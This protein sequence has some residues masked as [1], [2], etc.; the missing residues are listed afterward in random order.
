[1]NGYEKREKVISELTEVVAEATYPDR[2]RKFMMPLE[3]AEQVLDLLK[4]H[5]EQRV[6]TLE[7]LDKHTFG[8]DKHTFGYVWIEIKYFDDMFPARFKKVCDKYYMQQIDGLYELDIQAYN[9]MWRCWTSCPT[10]EQREAIP[11]ETKSN[12]EQEVLQRL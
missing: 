9:I 10:D 11:F 12:G 7:E 8:L 2:P 6:I 1:M 3:L 5:D 4:A